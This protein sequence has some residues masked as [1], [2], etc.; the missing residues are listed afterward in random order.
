MK[1]KWEELHELKNIES[2]IDDLDNEQKAAVYLAQKLEDGKS[3][4]LFFTALN[5]NKSLKEIIDIANSVSKTSQLAEYIYN[6]MD[7]KLLK[8]LAVQ[9]FIMEDL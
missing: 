5:M 6:C 9:L 8:D 2:V 3:R 7:E 4:L 1:I